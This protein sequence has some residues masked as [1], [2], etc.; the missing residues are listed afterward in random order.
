MIIRFIAG[1]V[2]SACAVTIFT[3][4]LTTL[5]KPSRLTVIHQVD[6]ALF[7]R[8][9]KL[10]P[11]LI[12]PADKDFCLDVMRRVWQSFFVRP[13]QDVEMDLVDSI[14]AEDHTGLYVYYVPY[15]RA[16]TTIRL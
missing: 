10:P 15:S 16:G 9:Y 12:T 13:V 7:M 2:Q 5:D 1:S 3:D 14:P 11:G 6:A 4:F 8:L